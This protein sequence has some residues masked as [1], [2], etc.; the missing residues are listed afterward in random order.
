M[1]EKTWFTVVTIP[2]DDPQVL[3]VPTSVSPSPITVIRECFISRS[4]LTLAIALNVDFRHG[5]KLTVFVRLADGRQFV[6][7]LEISQG[8]KFGIAILFLLRE[9][10]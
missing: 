5:A 6:K 7:S 8:I 1:C 3:K 2:L 4:F 10:D 9:P